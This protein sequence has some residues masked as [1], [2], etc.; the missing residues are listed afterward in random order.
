MLD[1]I[2]TGGP[3]WPFKNVLHDK[4]NAQFTDPVGGLYKHYA[5]YTSDQGYNSPI[6]SYRVTNYPFAGGVQQ[7]IDRSIL[8]VFGLSTDDK[9]RLSQIWYEE[10]MPS[11]RSGL[12]LY[13][14]LAELDELVNL[15]RAIKEKWLRFGQRAVDR[16]ERAVARQ[17]AEDRLEVQAE[18][19]GEWVW[20]DYSPKGRPF[21]R[22]RLRETPARVADRWLGYNF[23]IKPLI[24]DLANL[25][26]GVARFR[27]N[28]YDLIE[29]AGLEKLHRGHGGF[30]KTYMPEPRVLRSL[31]GCFHKSTCPACPYTGAKLEYGFTRD[32]EDQI[33]CPSAPTIE[34]YGITVLYNYT[35]PAWF[36]GLEA[37]TRAFFAAVGLTPQLSSVWEI[38]PFSFIVDWFI[39]VGN[40]LA[41][42]RSDFSGVKTNVLDV[43]VSKDTTQAGTVRIKYSCGLNPVVQ[44][45]AVMRSTYQRWTGLSFLQTL[46]A[47]R[48]PNWFQLSLGGALAAA[49]IP[50]FRR[51]RARG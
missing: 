11:L 23:A 44:Q 43:V 25:V 46:P 27:A 7:G 26:T 9:W 10:L 47:W 42:A 19:W 15:A 37:T 33:L 30:R 18:R 29:G 36:N 34:K 35:L 14:F 51:R 24:S 21:T 20:D 48:W 6:A 16:A 1:Y 45:A 31:G 13:V 12:D 49:R 17:I 50:W 22:I 32:G 40:L 4:W 3:P 41:R 39:P 8:P 2:G 5:W 38:I 28:A